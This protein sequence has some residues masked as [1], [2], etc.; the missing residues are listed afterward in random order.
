MRN[1]NHL[2]HELLARAIDGELSAQEAALVELHLP[3]CGQCR[4]K[5]EAFRALSADLEELAGR[6]PAE[7]S[8]EDRETLR[9]M[10]E[11][12]GYSAGTR[13]TPEKVLRRF[14]WGLAIAAALA[15]AVTVPQFTRR[16]PSSSLPALGPQA[17]TTIDVGGETFI[18]LPYS[19]PDLPLGAPHIVEMRV[20]VASL[21]DAGVAILEPIANGILAPDDSVPADVL[22]GLDGQPLGVHVLDTEQAR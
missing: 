7:P 19:N 3:Q 18:P 8:A 10:L 14:G 1:S 9:R 2:E 22:L 6:I 13:Q 15:I 5:Q 4:N 17:A 12:Q 20:P 21:A 16:T 11:A